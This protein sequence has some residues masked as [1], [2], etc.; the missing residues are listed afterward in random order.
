MW[1]LCMPDIITQ[2]IDELDSEVSIEFRNDTGHGI[3][4]YD[5]ALRLRAAL[6]AT[7][8]ETEAGEQIAKA[9]IRLVTSVITEA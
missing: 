5:T 2:E 7:A 4:A 6:E 8:N 9:V 1:S 3:S